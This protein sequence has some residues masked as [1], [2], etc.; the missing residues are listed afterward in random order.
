MKA[1]RMDYDSIRAVVDGFTT[2]AYTKY[3]TH[4]F[5]AGYCNS[6]LVRMLNEMPM[7]RQL[8]YI[9][10]L[11]ESA[12]RLNREDVPNGKITASAVYEP[13]SSEVTV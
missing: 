10:Q 4:A 2:D 11:K 5:G 1:R 3:G 12:V 13:I 6:L 9:A 7:A 8:Q